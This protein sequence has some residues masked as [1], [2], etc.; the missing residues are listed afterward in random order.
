MGKGQGQRGTV[1]ASY[2][3]PS[4]AMKGAYMPVCTS[5]VGMNSFTS[6]QMV[7]M[8]QH[9]S[10]L[11]QACI[12]PSPTQLMPPQWGKR[13]RAGK[14][15]GRG[16]RQ[17]E[18]MAEDD[19]GWQLVRHGP[20]PRSSQTPPEGSWTCQLCGSWS[21][22]SR[23]R[24]HACARK[25]IDVELGG[26]VVDK[27]AKR[28]A[29]KE[30]TLAAGK[31]SS[32]PPLPKARPGKGQLN[33]PAIA[34]LRLARQE[35]E[36]AEAE[37]VDVDAM[38]ESGLDAVAPEADRGATGV[39]DEESADKRKKLEQEIKS[40]KAALA[41]VTHGDET[42][43]D[44]VKFLQAKI[45]K[46]ELMRAALR[47]PAARLQ[48]A[49]DALAR[50]D[51]RHAE[52]MEAV[53]DLEAALGV[54]KKSLVEAGEQR[55]SAH[56]T[57]NKAKRDVA[58]Y[59]AE[60]RASEGAIMGKVEELMQAIRGG[61]V[62]NGRGDLIGALDGCIQAV[63]GTAS[64]SWETGAGQPRPPAADAAAQAA[65]EAAEKTASEAA[66]LAFE[67]ANAVLA[68]AAADLQDP[69]LPGQTPTSP[70]NSAGG[71]GSDGDRGRS[72]SPQR[73]REKAKEKAGR[74]CTSSPA[75][76]RG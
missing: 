26:P 73:P 34:S 72:R 8:W 39:G 57:W 54:A 10:M 11:Q 63:K 60:T 37:E 61:S 75:A 5:P 14:G 31:D 15:K 50:A 58:G 28:K 53:R 71:R 17:P 4:R 2:G 69:T 33:D 35:R 68:D 3:S 32:P 55:T 1:I 67:Q 44:T 6:P 41:I 48:S 49:Q 43:K 23:H 16:E 52:A 42:D 74:R 13:R 46:A 30:A 76:D 7:P 45:E 38:D 27:R 12:P 19:E 51:L 65:R 62:G 21:W 25:R 66:A 22:Q 40:L 29:E 47:P 36:R 9:P 64:H 18:G 56:D 59:S 24:C 70:A 20:G